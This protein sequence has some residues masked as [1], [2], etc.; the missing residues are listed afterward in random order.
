MNLTASGIPFSLP[1]GP[2]F[3][4]VILNEVAAWQSATTDFAG[5]T[6]RAS[7]FQNNASAQVSLILPLTSRARKVAPQ[8]GDLSLVLSPG[9]N[10]V[11]GAS[12][13]ARMS[14]TINWTPQPPLM[15]SLTEFGRPAAANRRAAARPGDPDAEHPL[16]RLRDGPIGAGDHH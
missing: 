1:A 6:T 5:G 7:T 4:N 10:I 14:A 16:L 12:V 3:T 13:A 15:L 8:L 2:V 9:F 11:T